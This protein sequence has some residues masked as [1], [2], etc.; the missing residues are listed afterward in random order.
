MSLSVVHIEQGID[1][2]HAVVTVLVLWILYANYRF[3]KKHY[4]ASLAAQECVAYC[5][6]TKK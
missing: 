5:P 4:N 6:R 1:S 2:L 3:S